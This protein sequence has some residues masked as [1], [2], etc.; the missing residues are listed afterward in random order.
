M[1]EAERRREQPPWSYTHRDV[2]G[3]LRREPAVE[4][5]AG[6]VAGGW[7]EGSEG[8]DKYIWIWIT[9]RSG[10]RRSL[11]D[12]AAIRH[13]LLQPL[14]HTWE[15]GVKAAGYKM[16]R[17]LCPQ[18]EG[19][20]PMRAPVSRRKGGAPGARD[21]ASLSGERSSAHYLGG[22]VSMSGG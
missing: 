3:R 14:S 6:A 18:G 10:I 22:L 5:N 11:K 8:P 12:S 16:W 20:E 7:G 19:G 9:K 15:R 4:S 13:P 2:D 21:A 17:Y 1:E